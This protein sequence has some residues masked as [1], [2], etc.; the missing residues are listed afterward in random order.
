MCIGNVYES[1]ISLKHDLNSAF[2]HRKQNL[3]KNKKTLTL[4]QKVYLSWIRRAHQTACYYC[5]PFRCIGHY[6]TFRIS[7]LLLNIYANFGR[8]DKKIEGDNKNISILNETPMVLVIGVFSWWRPHYSSSLGCYSGCLSDWSSPERLYT[9]SMIKLRW[10]GAICT[11]Y[12]RRRQLSRD[13]D[14]ELKS[15]LSHNRNSLTLQL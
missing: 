3:K 15:I 2:K 1:S 13:I 8:K 9:R 6:V 11:R 5:Y 7:L 12:V 10:Q 14:H 4:W